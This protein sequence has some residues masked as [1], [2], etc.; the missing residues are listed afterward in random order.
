MKCVPVVLFSILLVCSSFAGCVQSAEE[1]KDTI[2]E[3]GEEIVE[4]GKSLISKTLCFGSTVIDASVDGFVSGKVNLALESEYNQYLELDVPDRA[5]FVNDSSDMVKK[6]PVAGLTKLSHPYAKV[7]VVTI[8]S[9]D[10]YGDRACAVITDDVDDDTWYN[11]TFALAEYASE[12]KYAPENLLFSTTARLVSSLTDARGEAQPPIE[13]ELNFVAGMTPSCMASCGFDDETLV[14]EE[15]LGLTSAFGVTRDAESALDGD[16][17]TYAF[18]SAFLC[19]D[20]HSTPEECIESGAS[21]LNIPGDYE[22]GNIL[23]INYQALFSC[24]SEDG[25]SCSRESVSIDMYF[26]DGSNDCSSPVSITE[27]S[28]CN[29]ETEITKSA[30]SILFVLKISDTHPDNAVSIKLFELSQRE[31]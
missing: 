28:D 10:K 22:Q 19:P 25:E 24:P 8:K 4:A 1:V 17:D 31:G 18:S 15:G 5:A 26:C 30:T 21:V 13:L 14:F 12:N 7:A 23:D 9:I 27:C 6:L 2:V 16:V 20:L 11:Y 29:G 3:V